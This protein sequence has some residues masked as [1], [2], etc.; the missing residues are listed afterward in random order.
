[1]NTNRFRLFDFHNLAATKAAKDSYTKYLT[2]VTAL[3]AVDVPSSEL[4][5]AAVTV[6]DTLMTLPAPELSRGRGNQQLLLGPHK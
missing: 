1:M 3:L 5:A 2:T 6:W 4:H